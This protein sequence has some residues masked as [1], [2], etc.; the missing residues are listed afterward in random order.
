MGKLIGGP[1][2]VLH[3]RVGNLVGYVLKGQNVMRQIGKSEKPL[4]PARKANCE[5]MTVVNRFLQ[6]ALPFIQVGF[7]FEVA[8]TNRN[9]YN[10]AVSYN[11]MN[12]LKGEYPDIS[13]DYSKVL[14]SKGNLA[15]AKQPQME[16]TEEGLLFTWDPSCVSNEQ[17]HDRVMLLVC[18]PELGEMSYHPSGSKRSDGR[19]LLPIE[20]SFKDAHM[21]AYISFVNAVGTK[22]SDSVYVGSIAAVVQK[23]PEIETENQQPAEEKTTVE[24]KSIPI[25]KGSENREEPII[26]APKITHERNRLWFLEALKNRK[27]PS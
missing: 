24:R 8:G 1:F 4:T 13:M 14:V 6:P 19:D 20:W 3:G 16:R 18:F 12:A 22:V 5:K 15:V 21:E 23:S 17:K 11:K 10:E 9:A 2:G 25:S 27:A 7:R 26:P